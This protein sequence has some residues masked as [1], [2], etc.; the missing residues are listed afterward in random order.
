M[1]TIKLTILLL[2]MSLTAYANAATE[3]DQAPAESTAISWDPKSNKGSRDNCNP[4][5][6]A[7]KYQQLVG[8]NVMVKMLWKQSSPSQENLQFPMTITGI[9]DEGLEVSI[10]EFSLK[11]H[12]V[13]LFYNSSHL[14]ASKGT[15]VLD[16]C[17]A[18]LSV[19]DED[20]P[21]IEYHR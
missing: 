1:H 3:Q 19:E 7:K 4:A 18:Q 11:A 2:I 8:K 9:T 15:T 10:R 12:Y 16:I 21:Y 17:A 13:P 20:K 6:E 14:S 5:T